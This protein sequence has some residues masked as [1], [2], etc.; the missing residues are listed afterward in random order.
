VIRLPWPLAFQVRAV[1]VS[2]SSGVPASAADHTRSGDD[3]T[4]V[5]AE[6]GGAAEAALAGAVDLD[7]LTFLAT[8]A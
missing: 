5:F 1:A 3:P 7:V 8:Y 2:V 4:V 6:H